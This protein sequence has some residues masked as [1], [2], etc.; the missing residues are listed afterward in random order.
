MVRLLMLLVLMTSMVASAS[1]KP[2]FAPRWSFCEMRILR[3]AAKYKAQAKEVVRQAEDLMDEHLDKT[4]TIL[5]D[6]NVFDTVS[7]ANLLLSEVRRMQAGGDGYGML[8]RYCRTSVFDK[9]VV[10][11]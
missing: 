5:R 4:K 7:E 10:W 11:N 9:P 8:E 3:S 2:K 6:E 1:Q